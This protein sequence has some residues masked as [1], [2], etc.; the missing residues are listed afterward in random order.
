MV[1]YKKCNQEIF[2]PSENDPF[3]IVRIKLWNS[4]YKTNVSLDVL[5]RTVAHRLLNC[6]VT[7]VSQPLWEC[8]DRGYAVLSKGTV[9]LKSHFSVY[10]DLYI[11][12]IT[13]IWSALQGKNSVGPFAFKPCLP[14]FSFNR[15]HETL[16]EV[17]CCILK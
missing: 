12:L 8:R 14:I 3:L 2:D 5:W 7:D 17:L 1:V 11:F 6:V 13:V 15:R 9:K 10:W 16:W 4:R